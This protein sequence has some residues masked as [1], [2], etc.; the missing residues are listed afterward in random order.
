MKESYVMT[1]N[2]SLKQETRTIVTFFTLFQ[3]ISACVTPVFT[4][5]TYKL[6]HF[7]LSNILRC[8]M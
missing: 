2:K 4:C 7:I 3:Y 1:I 8:D 6:S 5:S